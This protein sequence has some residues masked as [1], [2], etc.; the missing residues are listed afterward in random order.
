MPGKGLTTSSA[1]ASGTATG[2]PLLH[3]VRK[4]LRFKICIDLTDKEE[5]KRT[6]GEGWGV[7]NY[8][9]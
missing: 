4:P 1:S 5:H 7:V 6:E 3:S 2:P 9:V 8:P